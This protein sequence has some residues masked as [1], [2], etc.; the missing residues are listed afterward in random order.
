MTT[1]TTVNVAARQHWMA[2][3]AQAPYPE[4]SRRWQQL[5][6]DPQCEVIRQPEVGL[7]RLQGRVG[8]SGER[9]NLGDTTITRATVRLE[10]GTLGYGYLR[11]RA[12]QHALL[13]AIIDALMQSSEYA[14]GLQE[15]VIQPL[16]ELQLQ[17][18]RQT[19][20]QAA[21]SKVDFFTVVRGED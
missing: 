13:S 3:L 12:K 19:A 15:T 9:F 2:V 1:A 8:G 11:G 21:E 5:N 18:L 7:A 17:A 4:L 10:N 16:A 6:L 20:E 14:P